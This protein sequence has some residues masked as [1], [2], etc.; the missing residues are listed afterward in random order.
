MRARFMVVGI[1]LLTGCAE[2]PTAPEV[3][4]VKSVTVSSP[5]GT[6][7]AV[8]RTAALSATAADAAG[9]SVAAS[10]TWTSA[11][12]SV[13]RVSSSGVVTGIGRGGTTITA[14]ADGVSG[15]LD[16]RVADADLDAIGRL[17]DDP[18]GQ[19]L[20]SSIGG[21]DESALRAAWSGCV[22]G[23]STGNLSAVADCVAETRAE[24][25]GGGDPAKR[26]LLSLLGLFV[27]WIERNLNLS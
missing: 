6:I 16:V 9:A 21:A 12:E 17:L 19:A 22:A 20:L 2:S 14:V 25:A 8:G 5:I 1:C 26:P 11:D 24:L 4:G 18:L 7:L 10:F 27:D 13:A 23:E 15:R 3:E